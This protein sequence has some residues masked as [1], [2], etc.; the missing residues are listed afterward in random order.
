MRALS[1]SATAA[2]T[3]RSSFPVEVDVPEEVMAEWEW[4]EEGKGHREFLVPAEIVNRY[5]PPQVREPNDIL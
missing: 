5:G 3:P 4:V 1:N 2:N